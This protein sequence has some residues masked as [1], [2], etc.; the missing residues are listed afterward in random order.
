ML[1]PLFLRRWVQHFQTGDRISEKRPASGE[2][3]FDSDSPYRFPYF[4][5]SISRR[6]E[7]KATAML[8]HRSASALSEF[9]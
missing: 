3:P 6:I 8:W 5:R 4:D 7:T 1:A 2:V 9:T